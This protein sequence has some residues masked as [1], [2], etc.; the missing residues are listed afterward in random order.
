MELKEKV[1]D[2]NGHEKCIQKNSVEET[3]KKKLKEKVLS[4][5]F[6]IIMALLLACIFVVALLAVFVLE[7]QG[8]ISNE[9]SLT[10][11]IK[12][13]LIPLLTAI[14]FSVG[15]CLTIRGTDS[16]ERQ[17]EALER[18]TESK[19]SIQR[20]NNITENLR[21]LNEGGVMAIDAIENIIEE[22]NNLDVEKTGLKELQRYATILCSFL[23]FDSVR[24]NINVSKLDE[25][26]IGNNN[27]IPNWVTQRIIDILY[28]SLKEDTLKN[29]FQTHIGE[30]RIDLSL[31][32]LQKIDFSN[33]IIKKTNFGG[34]AMHGA[35]LH[36]AIFEE[37][38][39]WGTYLQSANLTNSNFTNCKFAD[40]KLIWTNLC[41]TRLFD[42]DFDNADMSCVILSKS[43]VDERTHF[44]KAVFDG[45]DIYFDSKDANYF[46]DSRLKQV[47]SIS[48]AFNFPMHGIEN[49]EKPTIDT[50]NAMPQSPPNRLER[51]ITYLRLLLGECSN[52]KVATSLS[53]E[54]I[55]KEQKKLLYLCRKALKYAIVDQSTHLSPKNHEEWT[56]EI[57]NLMRSI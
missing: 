48:F 18:D 9:L 29:A 56:K 8:A 20:H 31:C 43:Q 54:A 12:E 2:N 4:P 1:M 13:V 35:M 5:D 44:N 42:C 28:P 6:W 16:I 22:V 39:F 11:I 19:L 57:E 34:A 46:L 32:N 23:K 49:V 53:Y 50:L 21:A 7:Y 37:C 25:L 27:D 3:Q 51:Y 36:D 47:E 26:W 52:R 40:S 45:A 14:G 10:T 41:G 24:T 38:Q 30:F 33:R 55:T 17:T 15:F